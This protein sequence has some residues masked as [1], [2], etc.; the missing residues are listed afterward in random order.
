MYIFS[1]K[2]NIFKIDKPL[3]F[4]FQIWNCTTLKIWWVLKL[5]KKYRWFRNLKKLKTQKVLVFTKLNCKMFKQIFVIIFSWFNFNFIWKMPHKKFVVI[6]L[7]GFKKITSPNKYFKFQKFGTEY[8]WNCIFLVTLNSSMLEI[9]KEG[10]VFL[11]I[12]FIKNEKS[13][14]S[15]DLI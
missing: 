6:D 9:S 7:R 2:N 14:S 1:S 3:K 15:F 12:Y 10:H 5:W 13:K 8:V 4:Y 11:L